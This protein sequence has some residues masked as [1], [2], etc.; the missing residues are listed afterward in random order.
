MSSKRARLDRFLSAKLRL[1]LRDTRLMLIQGR[2]SVDGHG[3]DDATRVVNQFSFVQCDDEIIQANIP[4]YI[5]MNKPAGVVSA[6]RDKK[7]RTVLDLL[8]EHY[9]PLGSSSNDGPETDFSDIHIAGRLDFN[10]T[11]LVLLTNDGRWSRSICK[12]ENRIVKTYLVTLENPLTDLSEREDYINS[13]AEGMF[14]NYE[15]ITTRPASVEFVENNVAKV[16]LVEGRYH[17]I[18]RMFGRF[19]NRVIALERIA[20]GTLC[21]DSSF[22]QGRCRDLSLAELRSVDSC[23]DSGLEVIR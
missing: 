23:F 14:F 11:G 22:A 4:R 15:N 3:V 18:K 17:Q 19:Q 20:I 12:P 21:L 6:T 5:V 13:F 1:S 9:R 10:S 16:E 2:I 7:H 8:R